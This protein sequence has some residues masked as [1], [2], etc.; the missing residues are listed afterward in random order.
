[1]VIPP[2]PSD[3]MIFGNRPALGR[4]FGHFLAIQTRLSYRFPFESRHSDRRASLSRIFSPCRKSDIVRRLA[5]LPIYFFSPVDTARHY[6]RAG[7][8]IE[9]QIPLERPADRHHVNVGSW[10]LNGVVGRWPVQLPLAMRS[11][12]LIDEIHLQGRLVLHR[13]GAALFGRGV[14][15]QGQGCH[16]RI[17]RRRRCD[18]VSDVC[19][20]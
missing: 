1:M 3:C 9:Q 8:P 11:I 18:A 12:Q 17:V 7:R 2:Q 14:P 19:V 13:Q 16:E 4:P 15:E 6:T 10:K 5:S 20:P